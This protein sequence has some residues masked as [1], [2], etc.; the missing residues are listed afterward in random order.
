MT[1]LHRHSPDADS[2]AQREREGPARRPNASDRLGGPRPQAVQAQART[3]GQ[4]TPHWDRDVIALIA[5]MP[6]CSELGRPWA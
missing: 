3:L 2:E 6:G 1:G 5:H 4:R